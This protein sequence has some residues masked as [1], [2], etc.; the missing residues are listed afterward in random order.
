MLQFLK[1]HEK[2]MNKYSKSKESDKFAN[3]FGFVLR[4]ADI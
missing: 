4:E 2:Q 1:T 3:Q